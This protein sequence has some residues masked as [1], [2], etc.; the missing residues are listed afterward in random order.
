MLR[1]MGD[2]TSIT[3]DWL[4]F[5]EGGECKRNLTDGHN[6]H[7]KNHRDAALR[8]GM[9]GECTTAAREVEAAHYEGGVMG[10][11][12]RACGIYLSN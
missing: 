7:I 9:P 3:V 5:N 11:Q 2:L 1:E 12:V 6:S 10:T 4:H 8:A